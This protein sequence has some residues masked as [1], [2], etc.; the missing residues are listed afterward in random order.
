MIQPACVYITHGNL[1]IQYP[2]SCNEGH[3]KLDRLQMLKLKA[4]NV[5]LISTAELRC[6]RES[7]N[8]LF[9]KVIHS[10][11]LIVIIYTAN[12]CYDN[13]ET[14]IHRLVPQST[15]EKTN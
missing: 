12:K 10:F 1:H 11:T 6:P 7:L 2:M 14:Y 15:S 9:L 5:Q 13:F 4:S 3:H 8:A